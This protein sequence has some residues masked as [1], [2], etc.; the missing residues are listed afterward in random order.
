MNYLRL[1]PYIVILIF[2]GYI[3]YKEFS[4]NKK[5][6]ELKDEIIAMKTELHDYKRMQ[7][8]LAISMVNELNAINIKHYG[9]LND[10]ISK[11][12]ATVAT[13]NNIITQLRQ[14]S[15]R[16][17]NDWNTYSDTTKAALNRQIN[18][19]FNRSAELLVRIAGENDRNHEAAVTYYN[20]LVDYH[21]T[22]VANQEKVDKLDK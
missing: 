8:E 11:I 3:G 2:M 4:N 9:E 14:D 16:T 6:S 22:S 5:Q 1:I 10:K 17:N 21:N 7:S 18:D 19:E 15:E 13:N 12:N 20:M